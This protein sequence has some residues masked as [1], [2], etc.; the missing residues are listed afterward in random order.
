MTMTSSHRRCMT[1]VIVWVAAGIGLFP[2]TVVYAEEQKQFEFAGIPDSFRQTY[3]FHVR[4]KTESVGEP[5]KGSWSALIIDTVDVSWMRRE[6]KTGQGQL[7]VYR[8]RA[9]CHGLEMVGSESKPDREAGLLEFPN[10]YT[11]EADCSQEGIIEESLHVVLAEGAKRWERTLKKYS[12]QI[13]QALALAYPSPQARAITVGQSWKPWLQA[14][15]LGLTLIL[16]SVEEPSG[17]AREKTATIELRQGDE[18][19]M[20]VGFCKLN[21]KGVLQHL[22]TKT[23]SPPFNDAVIT[24]EVILTRSRG[25]IEWD[26]GDRLE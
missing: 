3:T 9:E 8:I 15:V 6:L 19:G 22:Q 12:L 18:H 2:G 11:F 17:E 24:K 21:S 13:S 4:Q 7:S 25:R 26:N 10:D 5:L 20:K 14:R 1:S 23:T 16:V